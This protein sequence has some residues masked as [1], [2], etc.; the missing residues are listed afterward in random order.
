MEQ[1]PSNI[2]VFLNLKHHHC[3][4]DL[5]IVSLIFADTP[6][7]ASATIF[8]EQG[9]QESVSTLL[10]ETII[11]G[12]KVKVSNLPILDI[13]SNTI[14]AS[15]GAKIYRLDTQKIFYLQSRGLSAQ[16]A[17]SLLISSYPNQLLDGISL[18]EEEKSDFFHRFL[19]F[20]AYYHA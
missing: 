2:K 3:K 9:I 7:Q 13:Q 14:A 1:K 16:Q 11:I 10:E 5:H 12:D 4:I 8:M 17:Q 19:D 20:E 6:H 15:H 18:T